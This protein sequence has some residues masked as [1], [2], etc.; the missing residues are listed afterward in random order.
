MKNIT[1]WLHHFFLSQIFDSI[2]IDNIYLEQFYSFLN[3]HCDLIQERLSKSVLGFSQR[4]VRSQLFLKWQ[5]FRPIEK[6]EIPAPKR[7]VFNLVTAII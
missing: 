5:S 3:I 6:K 4:N 7:H 2:H 1:S